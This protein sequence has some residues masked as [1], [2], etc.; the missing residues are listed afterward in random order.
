MYAI[1]SYYE[2]VASGTA[3]TVDGKG[4]GEFE[5]K[6]PDWG[7]Y[8]LR[9]CDEDGGHCSGKVVYIDWPGWAGRAQEEKGE[10]ASALTLYTDKKK[11]VVGETAVVNLPSAKQA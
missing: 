3:S 4:T 7:R 9:A 10:G 11:Y 1:R 5:V 2:T 8:L 6:Y